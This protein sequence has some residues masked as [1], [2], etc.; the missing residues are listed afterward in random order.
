MIAKAGH[1]VSWTNPIGFPV[2]QR[3]RLWKNREVV[4][5]VGRL[6]IQDGK[7]SGAPIDVERQSRACPPNV[8]HSIDAAT[9]F[10]TAIRC[11][12][13]DVA[14][15]GVHDKFMTHAA[16][17]VTQDRILRE[18]FVEIHERPLL[19]MLRDEWR[20]KYPNVEIEDHPAFGNFDLKKVLHSPYFFA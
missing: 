15:A 5:S 17:R 16:T 12:D 14:F 1:D 20:A 7:D 13:K 4:T 6:L 11:R 9:M 10:L 18:V 8:I 3:D 2:V 19:T